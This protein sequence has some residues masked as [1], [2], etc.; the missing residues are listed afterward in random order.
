N[1]RLQ[2]L[3]ALL[4]DQQQETQASMIGREVKVLFE[5]AGREP[6]QMIGKSDYLHAVFAEAPMDV[7][8]QV[9]RV[10]IV[11]DSANSLKGELI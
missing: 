11:D 10:R 8:G 9:R 1:E 7:L 3:Q 2:R 5:K 6:G 4:R